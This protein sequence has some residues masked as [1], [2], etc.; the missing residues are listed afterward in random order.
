VGERE[1]TVKPPPELRI[2]VD[3]WVAEA[4]ARTRRQQGALGAAARAL[5]RLGP[6]WQLAALLAAVAAVP[7]LSGSDFVVRVG[8]NALLFALLAL[9]LNVIVGEAGLL[10]LGYIAFYGCGAYAYALL[11]SNQFHLHWPSELTIVLVTVATGGLGLLLGLPSRRLL[12]D[13][14]AIVTL[15]FGQM[16]VQLTTNLDR[17]QPPWASK[18]LNVTGGPNGIFGVDPIRLGPVHLIS[19]QDDFYLLL[20]LMAAVIV[21]LHRLRAS[22]TGRA[23]LALREDATAAE[24][25][26]IPVRRLKLFAFAV[27]GAI[28]GMSGTVFAAVQLGVFPQNF[29]LT[30][31][32]MIYAAV[33]LGGAG[34]LAGVL[35]GAAVIS[36]LPEVLRNPQHGRLLFYGLLLVVLLAASRRPWWRPLT[37]LGAT[38][39]LGLAIRLASEA[40][41]PH[42]VAPAGAGADALSRA[43]GAWVVVPA[44]PVAIGNAA[45]VVLVAAALALTRLRGRARTVA[46]VPVLWLAAFVWESRLATEPSVTR[47]LLLG[48]ILVVMMNARP[49]GL[50]GRPRVEA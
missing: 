44:S 47:Q 37:L 14:L 17:I 36:V 49:H 50:L 22:R 24:L 13:Y 46:L 9:G 45:F 34:S 3:D 32:I 18:P 33:V 6:G 26:G 8:I 27:G 10:D 25:A 42:A 2:G 41:W 43:L 5:E 15:F 48:A 23:W 39:A 1:P 29:D 21:A 30:L 38:V 7:L 4:G 20:G 31:L 12:G 35:L 40:I 28:A 19:L 11:S 16:F